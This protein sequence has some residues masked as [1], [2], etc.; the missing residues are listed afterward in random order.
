MRSSTLFTATGLISLGAAQYQVA[1]TF[2][3]GNFFDHFSFFTGADPTAGWVNY[4]DQATA[5]AAGLISTNGNSVRIG[6]DSTTNNVVAPGR[7]SVR[8]SS[9][10]AYTEML[11]VLDLYNM[12]GGQQGTWPAL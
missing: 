8:L 12:P 6:V 11:V 10:K 1:E 9:N 5:Q 4:V 7:N 2:T 3:D